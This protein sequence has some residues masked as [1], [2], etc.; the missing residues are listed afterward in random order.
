MKNILII[1]H[2]EQNLENGQLT[3]AGIV[4]CRILKEKLP[5]FNLVIA[6]PA[7]RAM[8]TAKLLTNQE[9]EADPRAGIA[10]FTPEQSAYLREKRSEHPLGVPGILF[11]TPELRIPAR[12][13]GQNL[14]EL[15]QEVL[16]RLSDDQCALVITHDGVMTSAEK[17]LK[18]EPFDIATK[19]YHELEGYYLNEK[20]ELRPM[21]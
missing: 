1:R 4:Q 2:A 9:P 8:A 6:S 17:I 5:R 20:L 10:L 13:A 14:I 12:A 21:S 16:G 19:T 7:A 15:V 11:S 18:Q 3:K